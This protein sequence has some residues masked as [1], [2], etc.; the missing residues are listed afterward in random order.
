MLFNS[1][2]FIFAYLPITLLGYALI[3]R[4]PDS[5]A[6]SI[7]WLVLCSVIFYGVWNPLNLLIIAPSMIVNYFLARAIQRRSIRGGAE[8]RVGRWLLIFG[9]AINLCFLGYFKYKNFFLDSV[10]IIWGSHWP[11]IDVILPLGISFITFQKIAF[12]VDVR[13]RTIRDFELLDFL[14]FV[15][16]FPQL[17]AG[18]I[19]HYREMVPQFKNDLRQIIAKNISVGL[20]LFAIGLFKK[21]VLADSIAPYA[22]AI[23]NT[24]E[25]DAAIGIANAWIGVSAFT[26]QVYFDFSGYSDMATGLARIFG[27]ILPMNFNS[28]LKASCIIDFWNRWHMTLTKF[29]TAYIY[30]PILL[31]VTRARMA[32][33]KLMISRKHAPVGAFVVLVAMPTM[34]TML[35]SGIWHGAGITFVLYGA[36]HGA[37]LVI[38]H[39]WRQWRPKWERASYDRVMRPVGRV[40]TLAAAFFAMSL[41]KAQTL[42]GALHMM[43]ALLGFEGFRI[44]AGV[45]SQAGVVGKWL[46][47]LGVK[48]DDSSG[49]AFL[50]MVGW[51]IALLLAATCLPNSMEMLSRFQPTLGVKASASGPWVIALDRRWAMVCALILLAGLL[52][53]NRVSE[54]LYWQF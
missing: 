42:H 46:V 26:L 44:P 2:A 29:L 15:F 30:S 18:P 48:G 31:T 11:L 40:L 37:Y 52:S 16:F 3:A 35:A 33:G 32:S 1:Y 8:D 9:I 6:L 7:W 36:L 13:T 45:L 10:N 53:L 23:F 38:N 22:T 51:T 34:I 24:A 39:A 17:I 20:G 54:F 47:A 28:P 43:S 19:V 27:I 41:F 50:A 14:I 49:V 25:G 12:L 5:R 21:T 4:R